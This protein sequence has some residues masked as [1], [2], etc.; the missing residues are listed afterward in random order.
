[1]GS[2]PCIFSLTGAIAEGKN[3][4]S[5]NF[6]ITEYKPLTIKISGVKI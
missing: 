1:M 2:K 5:G 4:W 3:Q 6:E